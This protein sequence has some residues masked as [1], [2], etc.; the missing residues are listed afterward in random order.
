[1]KLLTLNL[2]ELS[3]VV[4]AMSLSSASVKVYLVKVTDPSG[5]TW[6]GSYVGMNDTH[7]FMIPNSFFPP[8]GFSCPTV[9][10]QDYCGREGTHVLGFLKEFCGLHRQPMKVHNGH[11]VTQRCFSLTQKPVV[12]MDQLS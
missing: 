1:V 6:W 2:G 3:E 11:E 10:L 5:Y 7:I 12:S 4:P 8:P 9:C